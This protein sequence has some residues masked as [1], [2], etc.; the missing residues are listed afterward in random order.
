[1]TAAYEIQ[2]IGRPPERHADRIV[3]EMMRRLART[4]ADV[5]RA[6]NEAVASSSDGSPRAQR[7][8]AERIER[9]GALATDLTPG[10]RGRYTL[11]VNDVVGWDR[12]RDAAVL[13][14]DP[15]PDRPW[16]A[17]NVTV[18]E[19]E[20]RGCDLVTI[21]SK[22]MVLVTHHSMS[23]AA[24]RLGVRTPAHL[25]AA[26]RAIWDAAVGLLCEKG[27]DVD[28]FLD[29]PPEG[30]RVP[31]KAIDGAVVVLK[32]HQRRAALVA[33]TVFWGNA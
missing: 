27:G 6:I 30:W 32:R 21:R 7:K 15:I 8:M 25:V 11:V 4:H 19:S 13:V 28:A 5:W 22:P 26:T 33:A 14:G 29:A 3:G 24:Q 23:R 2:S 31:M 17:C 1:M 18:V 20:G 16:I 9:A 12:E 10:K